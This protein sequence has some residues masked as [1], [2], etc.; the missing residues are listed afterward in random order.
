LWAYKKVV[1]NLFIL[2]APWGAFLCIESVRAKGLHQGGNA[3]NLLKASLTTAKHATATGTFSPTFLSCTAFWL[4]WQF[5]GY[6]LL[7]QLAMFLEC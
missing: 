7:L 3:C 1:H 5:W 2:A 6:Y 4:F